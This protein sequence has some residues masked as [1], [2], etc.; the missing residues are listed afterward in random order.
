MKNL[1]A[2]AAALGRGESSMK[3][4][5][6]GP[7][8]IV[9]TVRAFN[10]MQDRLRR[11]VED[12]TKMLAAL[13]HDL[14]TPITSLRLRAEFIED[15]ETRAKIIETLDEILQMAEATLSFAR[16][17]SAHEDTRAVDFGALVSTVCSDLADTGR[18]VVYEECGNFALRCRPIGVKRAL[19]NIVENAAVYG[20]QARVSVRH[21]NTEVTVHIDDEGPGIPEWEM[22]KVFKPFVRLENSRNRDTGGVGLGLAIARSIIRSHGGDITLHNRPEGGLRATVSL[23]GGTVQELA[24]SAPPKDKAAA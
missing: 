10:D 2:A 7:R 5:E 3:L 13:G 17:E 16:E 1:A 21:S 15:E 9:E 22:E 19:R 4:E 6:Q 12:R 14:R 8:E 11:F 20:K 23:P 18:D 24:R